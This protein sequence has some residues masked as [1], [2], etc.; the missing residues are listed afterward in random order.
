[1]QPRPLEKEMEPKIFDQLLS[2]GMKNH[3]SDI[4]FKVGSPPLFRVNG[5]MREVK[6]PKL[7]PE[8]TVDIVRHLVKGHGLKGEIEDIRDYDASYMLEGVGRFRVNVFR[9]MGSLALVLRLIP[10]EV[11]TFE[12]LGLPPICE[13]IANEERGMVLVTG[14]TGSGK[15][16]TLAAI[17]NYI[18]GARRRHILTIEDPIEFV[19]HD[20]K[21]SVSQREIGIDTS[22]FGEA[23][24]RALRQD[25]DVILVGEMRDYETVDIALK[26]AETGHLVFSTVH[27]TDAPKTIN[28][29]TGVFP[30]DEQDLVRMRLSEAL[31][32][33]M[34]QRLL[35][36]L[37]GKGRALAVEICI[38]TLSIQ[39]CIKDPNKTGEM[40]EYIEK[41]YDQYGMQS[42][43]QCL[44][45]LYKTGVI[46]LEVAKSAA[47]N[48]ADF[49]RAL[50]FD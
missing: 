9:Q 48:P 11:P 28:R 35:P 30:A 32:A 47:S 33:I 43:D 38:N 31:R 3:A 21:S 41:G 6:A 23:L 4:H 49:E 27:T 10:L 14:V 50:N 24:R 39:E 20:Q 19:H 44:T 34:S 2:A 45:K 13:K 15:T 46:S 36:R 26:A 29:L 7:R 12:S 5:E 22:N 17:I 25:P 8:D 16:S 18:N 37:D 40:K 1:M 42:F